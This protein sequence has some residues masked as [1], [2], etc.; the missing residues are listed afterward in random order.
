[1]A[2]AALQAALEE[3]ER[4]RRERKADRDALMA[5]AAQEAERQAGEEQQRQDMAQAD[6]QE[7]VVVPD[8]GM[9]KPLRRFDEFEEGTLSRGESRA[10]LAAVAAGAGGGGAG[11]GAGAGGGGGSSTQDGESV[12][13]SLA[14]VQPAEEVGCWLACLQLLRG[15]RAGGRA[16]RLVRACMGLLL[17]ARRQQGCLSV[18]SSYRRGSVLAGERVNGS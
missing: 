10:L 14:D 8:D 15:G 5:V 7:E 18:G 13:D 1:M 12:T 2:A 6:E 16:G 11:A 4:E 3:D 9:L 17:W